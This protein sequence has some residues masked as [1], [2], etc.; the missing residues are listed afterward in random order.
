[1][2][3]ILR[4][5][6]EGLGGAGDVITVADGHAR[7]YL[8]PMQLAVQAT[9]ENQRQLEHEKHLSAHVEGKAKLGAEQ[10]AEQIAGV[11]CT[12][13]RRAGEND[14]LFGSVTSQ[15]IAEA[16]A[17]QLIEID[18]RHIN[19]DE[20]IR[21]LGVFTVPIHLHSEVV[22]NLQVVVEPEA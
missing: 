21:E 8:I 11:T 20:P 12:I 2:K 10:L 18:R 1:M 6:V 16:L 5:P 22:A 13:Q 4:E 3:V 7:N 14:R 19:M 17:A 9:E 15:N